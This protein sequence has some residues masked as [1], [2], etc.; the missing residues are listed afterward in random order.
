[1]ITWYVLTAQKTEIN[2]KVDVFDKWMITKWWINDEW[3]INEW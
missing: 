3:M 2:I 1:M